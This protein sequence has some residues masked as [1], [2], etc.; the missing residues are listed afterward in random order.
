MSYRVLFKRLK[1]SFERPDNSISFLEK[2]ATVQKLQHDLEARRVALDRQLN[3]RVVRMDLKM[4]KQKSQRLEQYYR[5]ICED[6]RRAN[7]RNEK[8]R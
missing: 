7:I 8:I 5:K 6:E 1:M 3:T 2:V 4:A